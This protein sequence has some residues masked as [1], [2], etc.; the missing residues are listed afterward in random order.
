MTE[1]SFGG[2]WTD[3]KLGRLAKYLSAY[4]QIFTSNERARHFTTWYVDAFAGT[5]SRS[6]QDA[7]NQ[8]PG[9]FDD[10][11]RD[12]DTT[13]YRD[14]SAQIALKLAS[15]FDKYLF[16]DKSKSRV[17]GLKATVE[18][19]H[20]N[21]LSRCI[22]EHGD[23]NGLLKTWC[24]KRDWTKER[25][26]VFL[27]PFGMQ[28]EWGIVET[29][30]ATKAVDLW[31]LFPLPTRLLTLDGK[32]EE[33]W[34]NRLDLFFG[35]NEWRTRF[36]QVNTTPDLFG[37]RETVE[38]TATLERIEAF[39]HERLAGCFVKVAKG[40][41]LWNSRSSP[42]YLLCFAAAN[43]KGAPTALRI[44]QHILSQ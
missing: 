30:A 20:P 12:T 15:P 5:G 8:A 17:N 26:V 10:I 28:V 7:T 43:E 39:I 1:N 9:L 37:D 4:R 41:I 34:E 11:Y 36:Y 42:L 2:T 35:T 14:G 44:A 16:I 38:R 24:G 40:L 29:L 3:D 23:A 6:I 13:E 32:M 25:A 31:Y 33:S 21:L 19:G 22:F 27:D 18:G